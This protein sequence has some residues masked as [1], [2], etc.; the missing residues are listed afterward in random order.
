[1]L[2]KKND[3]FYILM[4]IAA[5]ALAVMVIG[6]PSAPIGLYG[7]LGLFGITLIM[8]IVINPSLGAY[9]LILAIFTNI[10]DTM[11][12]QGYPSVI[13]PLT[14]VVALA[15]LVYYI[16][17]GQ[18]VVASH[19]TRHIETFLL[20]YLFMVFASLF[21]ASDKDRATVEILD[22][23]KDISILYC[24]VFALQRFESWKIAV[25]VV[26]LS[27]AALCLL[28]VYQITTH[29]YDQTF[30]GLASIQMEQVFGDSYTPRLSGPINAPNLWGQVLVAV[31]PLVVYRFFDER[32]KWVKFLSVAILGLL[33]TVIFNTYSRGAYVGLVVI[34]ALIVLER[35]LNLSVIF[36]SLG[37]IG[38]LMIFL[39]SN[40]VARFQTLTLLSPTTQ[41]GIYQD[42]SFLGR[43]SEVLT[44]LRMFS[45]NPFL[46]VGAGNYYNNYQKYAQLVGLEFRN[47]PREAHSLYAQLLAETGIMGTVAFFGIIFSL[48]SALTK[49]INAIKHSLNGQSWLPW[50]ISLRFSIISY[51]ITSLFLHGAYIRYFW[52]L[53]A[54]AIVVIRL[55]GDVVDRHQSSLSV[56]SNH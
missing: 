12:E 21:V 14:L 39:P 24:I 11:T 45:E 8:S 30:M 1:M 55:A 27:T 37:L 40:Y 46:G 48:F 6:N 31:V 56:E 19:K 42:S 25:W 47:E 17:A 36:A 49:S 52:I 15:I 7:L 38:I 10:S 44:G 23:V 54:L 33:L 51:L 53:V 5:C 16:Y 4:A 29:N 13:K 35:R 3:F 18:R 32:L 20:L 26:I 50:I 22:L 41:N 28:G 34:I 2:I 9:I 43:S